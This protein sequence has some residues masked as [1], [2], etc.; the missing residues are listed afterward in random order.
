MS[1]SFGYWSRPGSRKRRR[2]FHDTRRHSFLTFSSH[3]FSPLFLSV[4]CTSTK[5]RKTTTAA[6]AKAITIYYYCST[7]RELFR[8]S[9]L[10]LVFV[11]VISPSAVF[12]TFS[13]YLLTRSH[14]LYFFCDSISLSLDC[15]QRT[16][17]WFYFPVQESFCRRIFVWVW[18]NNTTCFFCS[19]SPFNHRIPIVIFSPTFE[20]LFSVWCEVI[21][22]LFTVV[23][24]DSK[25]DKRVIYR[26]GSVKQCFTVWI[27]REKTTR[28]T[29]SCAAKYWGNKGMG[30]IKKK[31]CSF[32][33]S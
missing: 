20:S 17:L 33:S 26:H 2:K 16:K 14:R 12:H 21:P 3:I 29:N 9:S 8:R 4:V 18:F 11:H 24:F 6:A 10:L 32:I 23:G 30:E 28:K 27:S 22:T 15:I 7:C 1:S 13:Y 25:S 19:S 31:M 5:F